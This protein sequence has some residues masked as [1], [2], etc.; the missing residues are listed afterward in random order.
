M[1]L[2]S[3]VTSASS[4]QY[5][6]NHLKTKLN[7]VCADDDNR[8]NV[9]ACLVF[10]GTNYLL[11]EQAGTRYVYVEMA[12]IVTMFLIRLERWDDFDGGHPHHPHVVPYLPH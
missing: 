5:N 7:E 4:A 3:I 9:A 6:A 12:R 1:S 8:G 10:L 11:D 2:Q